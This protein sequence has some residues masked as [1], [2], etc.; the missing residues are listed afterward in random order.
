MYA[1]AHIYF[2]FS[3]GGLLAPPKKSNTEI[4]SQKRAAD[5]SALSED[6]RLGPDDTRMLRKYHA[7]RPVAGL[8]VS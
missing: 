4:H 1:D 3:F 7:R 5:A 6:K 2:L 8:G